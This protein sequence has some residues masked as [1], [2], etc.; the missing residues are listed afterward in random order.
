M[1]VVIDFIIDRKVNYLNTTRTDVDSA[2]ARKQKYRVPRKKIVYYGCKKRSFS[3][4]FSFSSSRS[5]LHKTGS[6]KTDNFLT[7]AK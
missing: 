5:K 6:D 1:C 7:H 2:F 3:I 4:T